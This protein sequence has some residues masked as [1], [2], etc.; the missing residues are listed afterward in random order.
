M[1]FHYNL[2]VKIFLFYV[3]FS[4]VSTRIIQRD[5]KFY[6][7]NGRHRIFHGVNIVYKMPPYIPSNDTFDPFNSFN[8]EDLAYMKKFGFNLVRLGIMWES[9]ETA[10][11]VYNY[12]LLDKYE[13]LV[14]LLGQN[15]IYTVIDSHHDLVSKNFCGEGFPSFYV[16]RLDYDKDCT[17]S[18][19]K[20][21]LNLIGVCKSFG[22]YQI[23]NDEN[24]IPLLEDC[25]KNP[26][27]IYYTGPEVTSFFKKFYSNQEGI[28]D[29]FINYWKVLANK[30]KGNN[31]I[32]G[33]DLL[34]E[35]FPAAIYDNIPFSFLPGYNDQ[36]QLIPFYKK[37]D[38]ELREI[39]NDYIMMYEPTLFPDI[40][41][42]SQN[43]ILRGTFTDLPIA[44]KSKQMFNYHSYC[45]TVSISM[46]PLG[47]PLMESRDICKN[48]HLE[49]TRVANEYTSKHGIGSII[50]EFGSCFNSE[51]CFY[52]IS[53]LTEAADQYLT[54]WAYWMYKPFHDR[55]ST[56]GTN[57]EGM[58][59]EDGTI[60]EFKY[61][62]LTR[63]Y[64]QAFQGIGTYM[65]FNKENKQFQ[66]K[67]RLN[68][69]L[70]SPTVIYFNKELNYKNGYNVITSRQSIIDKSE[71][72]I[73]KIK[74]IDEASTDNEEIAITIYNFDLQI[75]NQT[76]KG[77][78][79]TN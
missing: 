2:F 62:A 68:K 54:S 67:F 15:G 28:L 5:S 64:V 52:E 21:F 9:I 79:K 14:N 51:S 24:G 41:P 38:Q 17:G 46:C 40:L 22:D 12:D 48:L 39:D 78:F 47:E 43:F 7:E 31:Y 56:S 34:N 20:R 33:F 71:E 13:R 55:T 49:N 58:F 3:L 35:P 66:A 1:Y 76:N 23:R 70:D 60:Q 57:G 36:T 44:D 42:I 6:D 25:I 29:K 26:F 45:C 19:L 61:K 75:G 11:G 18:L 74:I 77:F 73:L 4:S 27:Y 37:I 72:N 59:N 10:P 16:K 50:T 65:N 53:S 69:N 63:T 32:L 8:N 30:F